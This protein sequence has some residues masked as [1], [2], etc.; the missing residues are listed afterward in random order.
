MLVCTTQGVSSSAYIYKIQKHCLKVSPG[1]LNQIFAHVM[2]HSKKYLHPIYY[3]MQSFHE[4]IS[5]PLHLPS[6]S[7]FVEKIPEIGPFKYLSTGSLPPW[8]QPSL[9]FLPSSSSSY[10][11]TSVAS[12]L[13]V[14]GL[15]FVSSEMQKIRSV[16]TNSFWMFRGE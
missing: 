2:I 16:R 7:K 13:L 10:Y 1:N 11:I 5:F 12:F 4:Q 14:I 9:L 15:C 3:W 8:T 6:S